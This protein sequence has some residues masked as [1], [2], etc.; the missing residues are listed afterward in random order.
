M[1]AELESVFNVE[2]FSLDLDFEMDLSDVSINNVHPFK[3]P[4]K[5]R[6]KIYNRAAVVHFSAVA[7]F[8]FDIPCDRCLAPVKK[9]CAVP[10]EHILVT[11]LNDD[12]NDEFTLIDSYSFDLE[13]LVCE[14]IFLSFPTNFLCKDD[15]KGL[16]PV[17]GKNL[18]DGPCGCKKSIDPRLAVLEQLLEE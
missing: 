2:G 5:V 15:C 9:E 3:S 10:V 12:K 18:N 13:P 14:D 8:L 11:Q 4:V 1:V 17:C 7:S 16:C 6:G